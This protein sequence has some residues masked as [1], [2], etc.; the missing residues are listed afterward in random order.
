MKLLAID[1]GAKRLGLA[2]CDEA[3]TLA[4][5]HGTHHR[6]ANDNRGDI[7]A[8][9]ALIR[10]HEV[11]GVVMGAPASGSQGS[12]QTAEAAARF[13]AKLQEAARAA[14]LELAF[15]R[16][17]ER[18][19]SALA[20]RGL[21]ETGVS[22]KRARDEGLLDAGAACALLQTFLDT[23]QTLASPDER[24]PEIGAP[25]DLP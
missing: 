16:A 13:A 9:L 3:E 4:L 7:A 19:S 5:P 18:Y 2:I 1:Y 22:T 20:A 23:R 25:I 14:G 15:Y 17:D 24:A 6:R 11:G 12:A 10:A 8:L 21:R